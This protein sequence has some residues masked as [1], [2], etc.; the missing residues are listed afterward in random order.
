[1]TEVY[2]KADCDH[3]FL[4]LAKFVLKNEPPLDFI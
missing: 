4:Y 1:M 3:L 2:R